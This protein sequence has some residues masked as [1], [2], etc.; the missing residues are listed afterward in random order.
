MNNYYLHLLRIFQ[1]DI[2][3]LIHKLLN[4]WI[5]SGSVKRKIKKIMND[6]KDQGA[7]DIKKIE[8]HL[9]ESSNKRCVYKR[10]I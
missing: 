6:T 8:E 4:E 10:E 5:I 7:H 3:N 9:D 1:S 2:D